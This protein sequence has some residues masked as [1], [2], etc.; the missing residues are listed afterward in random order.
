V[1]E[2][3]KQNEYCL[4]HPSGWTIAKYMVQGNP[5][6]LLWQD[7]ALRGKFEA[8]REAMRMHKKLIGDQTADKGEL[9]QA[10]D[11]SE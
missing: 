4:S 1:G 11:V 9:I 2:W 5:T 7:H 3:T 6:Y 8:P 10:P